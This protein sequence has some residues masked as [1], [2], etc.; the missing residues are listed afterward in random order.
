MAL[1]AGTVLGE[2]RQLRPAAERAPLPSLEGKFRTTLRVK[3]GGKP[4]GQSRGDKVTR[5][6]SFKERCGK[7]S[8]CDRVKLMR[9]GKSGRFGS[10]LRR[11]SDGSS[12]SGVEKVR[13]RCGDGLR[14]S[15]KARIAV[16][17]N[18]LRGDDVTEITGTFDARVKGCLKGG[19]SAVLR[20]DLR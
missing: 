12:W 14:F 16:K 10:I 15:S 8:P 17:A 18:E 6:W 9:K 5:T 11:G 4:F 19:E 1:S 7:V 3:S 2:P 20:G 13:G